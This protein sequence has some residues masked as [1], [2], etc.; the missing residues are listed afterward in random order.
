MVKDRVEGAKHL[1]VQWVKEVSRVRSSIG[2]LLELGCLG[3]RVALVI[4]WPGTCAAIATFLPPIVF[5][6][7]TLMSPMA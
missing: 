1:Q 2:L 3:D 6:T 5:S 4:E 7:T